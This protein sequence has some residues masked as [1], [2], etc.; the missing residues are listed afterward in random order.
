[1]SFTA[2]NRK[3]ITTVTYPSRSHVLDFARQTLCGS[4]H[5]YKKNQKKQRVDEIQLNK[6]SLNSLTVAL[7]SSLFSFFCCSTICCTR[8]GSAIVIYFHPRYRTADETEPT[9]L[10]FNQIPGVQSPRLSVPTRFARYGVRHRVALC[11]VILEAVVSHAKSL[12]E[13]GSAELGYNIRA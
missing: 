13:R 6:G 1:M 3:S 8:S 11:T 5:T 4:T 7:R 9:P 10:P 12:Q 2:R